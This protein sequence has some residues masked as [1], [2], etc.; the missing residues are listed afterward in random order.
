MSLS[1]RLFPIQVS[2]RDGNLNCVLS[3]GLVIPP[4]VLDLS[5]V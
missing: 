5:V 1:M 4:D 2:P 3:S